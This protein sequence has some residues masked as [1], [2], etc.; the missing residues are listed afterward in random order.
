MHVFLLISS[1]TAGGA[2]RA[3]SELAACLAEAGWRVTLATLTDSTQSD[4]YPIH[5]HVQRV[6]L[7]NPSPAKSIVGKLIANWKRVQKLRKVLREL[8]P[9]VM[10]SFMEATNVLAILAAGP[11]KLP[12]VVAERTDPSQHL[13]HVQ[14]MWRWG[15]RAFY[16]RAHAVVAQTAGAAS[17]LR[18][19]CRCVVEVIP[20]A[21][22]SLPA[23]ARP[24]EAWIVSAGR[25]Q[26]VKGFDIVLSAFA[27]V[28]PNFPEWRLVIAGDGGLMASLRE[29]ATT[30]G[31]DSR[32]DWLGH[33]SDIEVVLERASI[34]ALASRYE[35][36]PNMLLESLGMG[37]AVI[38]TDCKSGPAELITAGCNGVLVPVDDIA[39]M[40]DSMARLAGDANLRERLG[41]NARA[42][43]KT[44]AQN[45]ILPRWQALLKTAA[46]SAHG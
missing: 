26:H 1:L 15:R 8:Q 17:W 19:E 43:R 39:A 24:R 38:A 11:L 41:S 40:A 23:P 33:R 27:R 28:A 31:I 32:V 3:M 36:F 5:A 7:G 42:V 21:L 16:R 30:L 6:C 46:D 13:Q 37:A 2:E 12:V 45:V 4:R 44:Y 35:G 18:T 10:L 29:M 14:P 20:N 22:R 25:L 9:D 34:V